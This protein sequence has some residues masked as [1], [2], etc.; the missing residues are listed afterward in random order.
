MTTS[1]PHIPTRRSLILL[2]PCRGITS[3]NVS[4]KDQDP[5]ATRSFQKAAAAQ[6][7]RKEM[8]RNLDNG[9]RDLTAESLTR[10]KSIFTNDGA[11]HAGKRP[12]IKFILRVCDVRT[13]GG[14]I[15]QVSDGPAA[16]LGLLIDN[17]RTIR[18]RNY[19]QCTFPHHG[20]WNLARRTPSPVS[21][22]K[23]WYSE[24]RCRLLRDQRSVRESVVVLRRKVRIGL[25]ESECAVVVRLPW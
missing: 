3:E 4:Y 12:H 9:I 18:R 7:V 8:L 2:S 22:K 20:C 14:R 25:G 10:L 19:R 6:K 1:L 23:G 15:S 21:L 16:A 13:N 11:T 5:F 24:E 17:C